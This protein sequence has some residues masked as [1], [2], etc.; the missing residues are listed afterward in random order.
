MPR[1][2]LRK[3]ILMSRRIII[4]ISG[5]LIAGGGLLV[6]VSAT[7]AAGNAPRHPIGHVWQV[8]STGFSHTCGIRT[9]ATLWCWGD[10]EYGQLGLG[11][12]K[13]RWVPRRVGTG[14]VDVTAGGHSCG[15]RTDA[16]LWC[17][18]YNGSGQLGLGDTIGRNTP[19]QVG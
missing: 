13:D 18:G 8:V 1:L 17:W 3:G 11:D 15:I 7:A 16:T 19:T 12:Q 14:W 2:T 10:N 5:C 6:G 9:D 4:A